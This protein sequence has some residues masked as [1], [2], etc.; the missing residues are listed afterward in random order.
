MPQLF[1][2]M[3]RQSDDTRLFKSIKTDSPMIRNLMNIE[4]NTGGGSW[5]RALDDELTQ[6]KRVVEVREGKEPL[7]KFVGEPL[8]KFGRKI[9]RLFGGS[10]EEKTTF[11]TTTAGSGRVYL[12]PDVP[13]IP[14]TKS[15]EGR[16]PYVQTM[17]D[18]LRHELGGH[19]M[20]NITPGHKWW[21]APLGGHEETAT[22]LTGGMDNE[23]RSVEMTP[24]G[25]EVQ[26]YFGIVP[27]YMS[28]EG[29]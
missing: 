20:Q 13:P 24:R 2:H 8:E 5:I 10:P 3:G 1:A 14:D 28:G 4:S 9:S 27:R 21:E 11:G 25:K 22:G 7:T 19:V 29:Y 16:N 18:T 6:Q 26:N 15:L 17:V 23:G 12:N